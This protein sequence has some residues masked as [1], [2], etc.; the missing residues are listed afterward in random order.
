MEDAIRYG[1]RLIMLHQ[2]KD[3]RRY[4]GKRKTAAHSAP[5][6]LALFQNKNSGTALKKTIKCFYLQSIRKRLRTKKNERPPLFFF[7]FPS[8]VLLYVS[9]V[10][11]SKTIFVLSFFLIE[12]MGKELGAMTTKRQSTS[13]IEKTPD[14]SFRRKVS[15]AT[16]S[17]P[18]K[19]LESHQK[20]WKRQAIVLSTGLQGYRYL[21]SD[22]LDAKKKSS[23]ELRSFIPDL[24]VQKRC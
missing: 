3:R 8:F 24:K 19:Y 4:P 9:T 6:S 14:F 22:V 7:L 2:V 11:S 10:V 15:T 5:Y 21:P 20:N 12:W 16:G 1:N 13:F 23:N 17:F 18:D